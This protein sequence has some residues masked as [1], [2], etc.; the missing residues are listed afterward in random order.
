[1][2]HQLNLDGT[3]YSQDNPPKVINA[4]GTTYLVGEDEHGWLSITHVE[5]DDE[6]GEVFEIGDYPYHSFPDK[7]KLLRAIEG[8]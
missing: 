1:M 5:I 8:A 6:T 3:H 4:A 7:R 2:Q